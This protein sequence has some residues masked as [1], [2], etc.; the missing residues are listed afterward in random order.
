SS[1]TSRLGLE[2]DALGA[3]LAINE[4]L[5]APVSAFDAYAVS[6]YF[7][8]ILGEADRSALIKSWME[9]SLRAAQ[10]AALADGLGGQAATDYVTAHRFDAAVKLAG[11][12][13]R[14]GALSGH[15]EGTLSDLLGRLWP[16]HAAVARAGGLDLIMY[17]GGSN[18]AAA[19]H[20]VE[21][22]ELIAFFDHLNHAEE[23]G[24]LYQTLL[25][26]WTAVGGQLFTAKTDVK[27][28]AKT[29]SWGALR[30]IDDDTPRMDALVNYP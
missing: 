11:R 3:P 25:E 10:A 22:P 2:S 28:P 17:A 21:D 4:G 13:L 9:E 8:G 19:G 18:V 12:E 14:D 15:V 20:G 6:G 26:G 30:H 1:Q 27:S 29:G 5:K 7:G 23:M 16:Y 24:A